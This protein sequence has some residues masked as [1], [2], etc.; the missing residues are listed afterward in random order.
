MTFIKLKIKSQAFVQK[1]K[2]NTNTSSFFFSFSLKRERCEN[3][4]KNIGLLSILLDLTLSKTRWMTYLQIPCR[5]S[6]NHTTVMVE[7]LAHGGFVIDIQMYKKSICG[8]WRNVFFVSHYA[9]THISKLNAHDCSYWAQWDLSKMGPVHT[10]L[11]GR[12]YKVKIFS[13]W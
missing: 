10:S 2:S 9:K 12:C 4:L 3:Y 13:S 11:H 6:L 5:I 8:F 1:H 7:V